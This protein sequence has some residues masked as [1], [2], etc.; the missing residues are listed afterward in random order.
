MLLGL[1]WSKD[2]F[3]KPKTD[4]ISATYISHAGYDLSF[5]EESIA[6]DYKSLIRLGEKCEDDI[7]Q[8][9]SVDVIRGGVVIKYVSFSEQPFTR[10][11]QNEIQEGQT[12]CLKRELK[13][14][15]S[16]QLTK[17]FESLYNEFAQKYFSVL[18]SFYTQTIEHKNDLVVAK[19]LT[20]KK[21]LVKKL[22]RLNIAPI[23]DLKVIDFEKLYKL[24]PRA[25]NY[26]IPVISKAA[27]DWRVVIATNLIYTFLLL[28]LLLYINRKFF[29]RLLSARI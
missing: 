8:F 20:E 2:F 27:D 24:R 14:L 29:L 26:K 16:F 4:S 1:V 25:D 21:E 28:F 9:I 10:G 19:Q 12:K 13:N 6:L 7:L 3:S 15:L 18:E 17:R 23:P 5:K 22:E 11:Q